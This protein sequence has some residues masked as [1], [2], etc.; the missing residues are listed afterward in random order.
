MVENGIMA[1]KDIYSEEFLDK[2][3]IYRN[4]VARIKLDVK[5]GL[6]IDI[7]EI[8]RA[9]NIEVKFDYVE[10]SGWSINDK[11]N[12][13][14]QI[15]IN[16]LEPEYRQRFTL[17]HEIGHIILGHTGQSYRTSDL[18]QYRGTLVRMKEVAANNFAAELIMPRKLVFKVLNKVILDLEYSADQKFDEYDISR[19]INCMS[20]E[21]NVSRQAL[22][23]RMENLGVFVNV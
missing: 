20:K 2:F 11:V 13:K 22:T 7:E 5:D 23:Y 18:E 8:A 10:H 4:E 21:L 14:R 12:A 19:I 1:Y 16:K 9:C 15:V 3:G 17:A 6:S